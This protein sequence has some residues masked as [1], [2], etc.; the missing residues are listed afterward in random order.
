M[1]KRHFKPIR[2]F[3]LLNSFNATVLKYISFSIQHNNTGNGYKY[4]E[5][6]AM[7][8]NHKTIGGENFDYAIDETK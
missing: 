7:R 8:P 5:K 1:S 4:E 6:G 2:S 3:E